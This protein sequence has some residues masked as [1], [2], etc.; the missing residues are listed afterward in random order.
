MVFRTN[1]VLLYNN[2]YIIIFMHR[3]KAFVSQ[4]FML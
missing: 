4:L 1:N 3:N 2:G